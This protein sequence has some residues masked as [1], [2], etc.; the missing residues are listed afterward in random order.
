MPRGLLIALLSVGT[1]GGFACGFSSV[2]GHGEWRRTR[3]EQRA[4]EA[5]ERGARQ[6]LAGQMNAAPAASTVPSL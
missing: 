3:L 2:R 6:A 1:I 4:M 5:C